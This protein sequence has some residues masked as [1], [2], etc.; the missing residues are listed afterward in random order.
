MDAQSATVATIYEEDQSE[1]L[2][3]YSLEDYAKFKQIL[4]KKKSELLAEAKT[5]IDSG[6]INLDANEM[7]DEVDLASCTIDQDLTFRLLDR[8]RK[9]LREIERALQKIENGDYGY[10]EGTGEIIPRKRL[11]LAPWVR[12]G[13]EHKS[14]LEKIKKMAKKAQKNEEQIIILNEP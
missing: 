9:L 4:L 12:H 7:K 11:E 6:K 1:D 3:S 5:I 13:V 14:H 2:D 10:C 8:A